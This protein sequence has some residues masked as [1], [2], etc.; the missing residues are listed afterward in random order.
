MT[1]RIIIMTGAPSGLGLAMTRALLDDGHR[2]GAVGRD[3]AAME[4]LVAM[5]RKG[6]AEDRLLAAPGDIRSPDACAAVVEAVMK[7]F[8]AV[9]AVVNN[10][11]ANLTAN[12]SERFYDVS[13][14]D[15]QLVL[16]TNVNGPF[17]LTRLVT[18][19][20]VQRGWGRIVNHVTG[21]G[22]MVRGGYTPYG[23]SKAA[24]EAA[25]LAWSDELAGTGVTVNAILPGSAADT[26]RIPPGPGL[27][28]STL[29]PPSA[30]V[31]PIRWL[32]SDA[33]NGITGKRIVGK[34]WGA[35]ASEAENVARAVHPAWRER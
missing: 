27:D 21:F 30:M 12:I 9:D 20:L 25:T 8:G 13:A 31:G 19:L 7:R 23:P 11:G 32:M 28:R 6:D 34:E 22:T 24:L 1:S 5:A 10:A 14:E 15:W 2:I 16:D 29:V 4:R 3:P 17:F 26:R 35:D 33:A 18:P